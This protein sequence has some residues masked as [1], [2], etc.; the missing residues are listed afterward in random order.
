MPKMKTHSGLKKRFRRNAK[1]DLK[2]EGTR[3]STP[4]KMSQRQRREAR[5]GYRPEGTI[6]KNFS[7][8]M[9]A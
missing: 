4:R 2:A 7:R 8:A 5:S 6:A 9:G 1:G 3:R